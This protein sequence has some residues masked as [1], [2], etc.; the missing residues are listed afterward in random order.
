MGQKVIHIE[1]KEPYNGKQHY[2]FGSIAAIYDTL[3][4][5]VVGIR[6]ESLWNVL[7][8]GEYS[9]R[10]AI[11]RQSTIITKKTNRGKTIVDHIKLIKSIGMNAIAEKAMTELEEVIKDPVNI[12]TIADDVAKICNKAVDDAHEFNNEIDK[13]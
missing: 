9:T 11:I 1:L 6:K 4:S 5:K 8:G 2:Y 3:P 12:E 13:L 7:H 10:E